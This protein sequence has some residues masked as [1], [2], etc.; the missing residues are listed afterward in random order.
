MFMTLYL[1]SFL[2][3]TFLSHLCFEIAFR[4]ITANREDRVSH[5]NLLILLQTF[6]AFGAMVQILGIYSEFMEQCLRL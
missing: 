3:I 1:I 6:G 5:V 2:T 4:C